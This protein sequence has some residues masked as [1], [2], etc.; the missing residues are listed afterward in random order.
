MTSTAKRLLICGASALAVFGGSG[1]AARSQNLDLSGAE[2][3]ENA[4]VS[5]TW[6]TYV[7][8]SRGGLSETRL[9][10]IASVLGYGDLD[11]EK[12]VLSAVGEDGFKPGMTI[13]QVAA[14]DSLS[15]DEEDG[16]VGF[17]RYVDDD[18]YLHMDDLG[19]FV[20]NDRGLLK[21]TG[22]ELF[23]GDLG[24]ESGGVFGFGGKLVKEYSLSEN[25][26]PGDKYC[27]NG[28]EISVA[29]G[30]ELAGEFING[31]TSICPDL[32]G[33]TPMSVDVLRLSDTNFGYYIK[34]RLDL[35]G[36]LL[37]AGD[38]EKIPEKNCGLFPANV[39]VYLVDS[40]KACY[41]RS[42]GL[43]WDEPVSEPC[44][45]EIGLKDAE[46]IVSENL[47]RKQ[48]FKVKSAELLY[49]AERVPEENVT[50]VKPMWQF[51]ITNTGMEYG[52]L[53]VNVDAVTGEMY[54]REY[55]PR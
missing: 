39:V 4:P 37:D 24:D 23:W 42:S 27:L 51:I 19:R 29:D 43:A 54:M 12:I 28:V 6:H 35:S 26:Y 10:E 7:F 3:T 45:I 40:N 25:E 33:Y 8:G 13:E 18:L 32:F 46:K 30:I 16:A 9:K 21:E 47:S 14:L 1:C 44:E 48:L 38:T 5:G 17:T 55:F 31:H 20:F 2:I 53:C 22:A 34:F 15:A 41:F 50:L 11:E 36:V 49:C 52:S